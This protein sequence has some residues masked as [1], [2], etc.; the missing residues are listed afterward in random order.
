MG[1]DLRAD[2]YIASQAQQLLL[3]FRQAFD[4]F[5]QALLFGAEFAELLDQCLV[6]RVLAGE[7]A[8]HFRLLQL[9]FGDAGVQ[10]DDL[11]EDGLGFQADVHRL[12]ESLVGIQ[13]ILGLF[14]VAP[15]FW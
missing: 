10:G 5:R 9:Q 11:V 13:G 7:F 15:H 4:F 12:A 8:V 14:E 3:G 6:G 1:I 2:L